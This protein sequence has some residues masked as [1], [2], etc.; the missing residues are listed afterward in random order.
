MTDHGQHARTPI[1]GDAID[2]H[3]S[4]QAPKGA[5]KGVLIEAVV[6]ACI[7]V[8]IRV[9]LHAPVSPLP[10]GRRPVLMWDRCREP[11]P[12]QNIATAFA[13]IVGQLR[14]RPAIGRLDRDTHRAKSENASLKHWSRVKPWTSAMRQASGN[15]AVGQT[16]I[17][18]RRVNR[19]P[20]RSEATSFHA[21][22]TRVV[23]VEEYTARTYWPN[24]SRAHLFVL[25]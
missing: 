22:A 2:D 11:V 16:S 18:L 7:G 25:C 3:G 12:H 17:L 19:Q 15:E 6:G 24:G 4:K 9:G 13:N 8:G 23:R 21:S 10:L 14:K 20:E 5:G 1:G